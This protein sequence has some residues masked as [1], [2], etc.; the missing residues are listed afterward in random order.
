MHAVLYYFIYTCSAKFYQ[1]Y[2]ISS[3]N[4]K[5]SY[6]IFTLEKLK[7]NSIDGIIYVPYR[8]IEIVTQITAFNK[9]V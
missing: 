9:I 4:A 3:H 7:Q 6:M 1:K 5:H 2:R 8:V